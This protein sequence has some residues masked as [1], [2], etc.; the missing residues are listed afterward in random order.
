MHRK[1][2][3]LVV[4]AVIAA[5]TTAAVAS[6]A[7][8][9]NAD[10]RQ[11]VAATS[12]ALKTAATVDHGAV[13]QRIASAAHVSG[14][15]TRGVSATAVARNTQRVRFARISTSGLTGAARAAAVRWNALVSGG[16]IATAQRQVVLDA[17]RVAVGIATMRTPTATVAAGIVPC[18]VD[19]VDTVL[20][21]AFFVEVDAV[22][23]PD[24]CG[25]NV[26]CDESNE[27]VTIEAQEFI[28]VLLL[29][30]D[31]NCYLF[32]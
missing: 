12:Q 30:S 16:A 15:A 7:T 26:F 4:A 18:T 29:E 32:G 24:N 3:L 19:T 5:S 11:S 9:T 13:L 27:I 1:I 28:T 23:I 31:I 8:A 21:V 20:L 22:F 2:G 14:T 17:P 10:G 25:T 6:T